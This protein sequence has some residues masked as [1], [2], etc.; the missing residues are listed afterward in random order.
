[1]WCAKSLQ[2]VIRENILKDSVREEKKTSM[3][4][5]K[6]ILKDFWLNPQL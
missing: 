5:T 1:M 3:G 4:I 6:A 2:K